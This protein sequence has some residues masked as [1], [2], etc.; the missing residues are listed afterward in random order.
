MEAPSKCVFNLE[1]EN[2][3]NRHIHGLRSEKGLSLNSTDIRKRAVEFYQDLY[4]NELSNTPLMNS[5]LLTIYPRFQRN[6]T[7]FQVRH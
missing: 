7:Q 1:K 4:K 6:S 3:Q 5:V 2:G